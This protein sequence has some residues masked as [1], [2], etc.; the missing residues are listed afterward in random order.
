LK[1]K[2]ELNKGVWAYVAAF[3]LLFALLSIYL[4]IPVVIVIIIVANQKKIVKP[5]IV[6]KITD[7][8]IDAWLEEDREALFSKIPN[9]LDV[10]EHNAPDLQNVIINRIPLSSGY[11]PPDHR[12]DNFVDHQDCFVERGVDGKTRYSIHVFMVIYLCKNFLA[13]YKCYWNFIKGTK[14]LVETSEYLYDTIVAV[15]TQEF[16]FSTG[17]GEKLVLTEDL[18]IR[19]VDGNEVNFPSVIDIQLKH[20]SKPEANRKSIVENAVSSIRRLLRERRIDMQ[21][22]KPFDVD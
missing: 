20:E 12:K 18:L 15:T 19:T 21:I 4:F 6:P 9:L 10:I 2:K 1:E 8:Q 16:S 7:Q 3:A 11:S 5:N 13:Y 22:V 14:T 17:E